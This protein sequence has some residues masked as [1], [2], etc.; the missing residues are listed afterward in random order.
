MQNPVDSLPANVLDALQRENMIEAIKLLRESHRLGLKEAKDIIDA[1]LSGR[2]IDL[3]APDASATPLPAPVVQALQQGN[4]IEAIK[5]L[6]EH[7]GLDLKEAKDMVEASPYASSSAGRQT[8]LAPG[9]VPRSRNHLVWIIA[10]VV[11]AALAYHFLRSA[12]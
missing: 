9:E 12:A 5:L 10:L 8:G 6:R 3:V 7:T 1:H 4:K 2:T 11:L